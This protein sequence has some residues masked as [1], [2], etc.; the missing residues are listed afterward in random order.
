MTKWLMVVSLVSACW[1]DKPAQHPVDPGPPA[2]RQ[3][4]LDAL[5]GEHRV[6]T[7]R[8][9]AAEDRARALELRVKA[10]EAAPPPAA[11][12]PPR[13]VRREPDRTRTYAVTVTGAPTDGPADAKVT[14][15]YAGEYACPYCEKAR[16]TLVELRKKYGKD[17]RVVHRSF[18]VHPQNATAAAH[19]ACAAHRQ[20]KFE[21]MDTLLWEQGF[22]PHQ[23]DVPAHLPDGT[24]QPC[25]SSTD[26]CPIAL[27]FAR[28]IG[29]DLAR[30]QRDMQACEAEVNES[31]RELTAL[32]VGATP[33]FYINGRYMSGAMPIETF[34]ALIDEEAA[35]ADARIK[36][37]TKRARYYQQW[38]IDAGDKLLAP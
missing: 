24:T 1:S 3:A 2:A 34:S 36:A 20:H 30:F 5:R 28:T 4:D 29:L 13:P 6:L 8:L 35:K 27:G 31:Q 32:G 21:A 11:A 26:G 12:A 22:K 7:A 25:W 23:F 38:V 37:G 14:L 18:I 33:S 10:L 19:A 16:D 17:L 9:E 15:V